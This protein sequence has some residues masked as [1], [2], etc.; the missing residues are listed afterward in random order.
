MSAMPQSQEK[1]GPLQMS[2]VIAASFKARARGLLGTNASW[3]NDNR[4]LLLVR[5][6]SVHTFGMRYALDIAFADKQGVVLRSERSVKPRRM[7]YCAQAAFVLERPHDQSGA[8]L[9]TGESLSLLATK[10]AKEHASLDMLAASE[11]A[12]QPYQSIVKAGKQ[13]DR[14]SRMESMAM[15]TVFKIFVRSSCFWRR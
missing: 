2:L 7:L 8:W 5:C 10:P 12:T 6:R 11:V 14:I 15:P 9:R 4:V 1:N 3:G 13:N